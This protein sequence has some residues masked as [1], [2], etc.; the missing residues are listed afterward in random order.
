MFRGALFVRYST[1]FFGIFITA[2]NIFLLTYFLDVNEFSVWG[3]SMSLI[4]V[5][6]QLGQLTYV[7][8]VDK[9]FPNISYQEMKNKLYRFI[10]TIFLFSPIWF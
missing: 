1:Y 3:I 7:Q 10:K 6:S 4:Y 9:N 8:Y 2:L 5:L